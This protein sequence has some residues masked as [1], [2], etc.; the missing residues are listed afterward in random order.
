MYIYVF[1]ILSRCRMQSLSHDVAIIQWEIRVFLEMG[2]SGSQSIK[3]KVF[4]PKPAPFHVGSC[5]EQSTKV[6]SDLDV[7]M[8]SMPNSLPSGWAKPQTKLRVFF[9]FQS[10]CS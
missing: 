7:F 3:K 8:L 10:P 9:M 6:L 5:A 2:T 1:P 4:F